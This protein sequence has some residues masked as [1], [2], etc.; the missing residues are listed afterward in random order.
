MHF[1]FHLTMILKFLLLSIPWRILHDRCLM[2]FILF[3]F[4][5]LLWFLHVVSPIMLFLVSFFMLFLHSVLNLALSFCFVSVLFPCQFCEASLCWF[6][7]INSLF[8]ILLPR[9][10]RL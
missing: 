9:N 10:C 3:V 4:Y 8:Q 1:K 2:G 5:L 6:S 7:L